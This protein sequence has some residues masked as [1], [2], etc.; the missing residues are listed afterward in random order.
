MDLEYPSGWGL[1]VFELFPLFILSF[2]LTALAQGGMEEPGWRG[3]LQ[4]ALQK[5]FSPLAAALIVS[6]FWSLWHLPLYLNGFYPGDLVSG[7]IG[8]AIYR[9]FLAIFL[10]WFYNRTDGNLFLMV[11][12]H[13][14]FNVIVDFL[15]L[16]DAVMLLLW[17]VVVMVIVVKDRMWR[18]VPVSQQ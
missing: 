12:M 11:L 13:T 9:V 2:I 15:P 16:S 4:P 17:V 6:V 7:M 3:F 1:P 18:R 5:R 10:A 14:C 8:G